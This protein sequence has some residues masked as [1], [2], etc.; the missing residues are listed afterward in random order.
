VVGIRSV[1]ARHKQDFVV[2]VALGEQ[3]L[4]LVP[5]DNMNLRAII[6]TILSS[7]TL[8]A[9]NFD[10]SEAVLHSA[11]QT[12]YR[13]GNPF[14]TFTIL[15]NASALALMRGQLHRAYDLNMEALR[16]AQAE[17]LTQLVFL[18]SLRLGRIHYFWNQLAQARGYIT[19]AIEH[20]NVSAY[21]VATVQSY[22]TLSLI[23]NAEDQYEQ[24]LQ[25]LAKAEAIGLE[26]HE[27]ESVTRVRGIRVQL[28]LLAGDCEA[29]NHWMKSSGWES[30]DPS[31]PGPISND[32]SFFAVCHYLINSGKPDDWK[33]VEGLLAWRLMDSEK[34][35]R[36]ST[37]LSI[38]L[39]QALLFQ[40]QDRA[41]LA[42]SA[43]L[44]ALEIA[45]PEN[46]ISP[47]LIEGQAL[48]PYLRRVPREHVLRNFAQ[49]VLSGSAS[50]YPKEYGLTDPLS[51]QEI[52]ILR[53]M[54]EGHTNPEIA[55][56]LMLAVSTVRWYVKQIF[57]KLGV[58]N[59]TQ[60]S[61]QARK[62][63]LL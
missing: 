50:E 63:D 27:T 51:E 11:R 60:A 23:Q 43:L 19:D 54:A 16:L 15:L 30:F 59:R 32:D 41:D 4:Q 25:N 46:Y 52:N 20:A 6:S 33:R 48:H 37:I 44:R 8:E 31:E 24:A 1:I 49:L 5:P 36:A 62:L 42:M 13:V 3:A 40:A 38:Y 26:Q 61:N 14:I 29:V 34:Q 58:H 17:S 55:R 28:Q 35:K 39:M 18:T 22:I 9:G 45:E 53:L 57:R 7:A 12:A 21:P 10:Q 47:F 56:R 2:A